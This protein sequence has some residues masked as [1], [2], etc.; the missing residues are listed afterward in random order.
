MANVCVKCMASC[1]I[2]SGPTMCTTCMP[3]FFMDPETPGLCVPECQV[4][5]CKSCGTKASAGACQE[6]EEGFFLVGVE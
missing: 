4:A 1:G 6:C 5:F 3:G 2:C